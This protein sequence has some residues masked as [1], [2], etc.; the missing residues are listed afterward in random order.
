MTIPKKTTATTAKFWSK[1]WQDSHQDL[2]VLARYLF[3]EILQQ[4][5][6]NWSPEMYITKWK[7]KAPVGAPLPLLAPF[8]CCEGPNIPMYMYNP[9]EIGQRVLFGTHMVPYV[10]LTLLTRLL[11]V[12]DPCLI[13][14]VRISV[15][16]KTEPTAELL[17]CQWHNRCHFLFM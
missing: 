5:S 8:S 9:F 7:K 17:S 14:K 15:L 3:L 12:D 11:G 10:V 16:I 13:K 4:C 1:T 6:S 2:T